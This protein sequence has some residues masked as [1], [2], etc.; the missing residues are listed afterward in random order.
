MPLLMSVERGG[1][2]AHL[3]VELIVPARNKERSAGVGQQ[4]AHE[5]DAGRTHPVRIAQ[6]LGKTRDLI[7]RDLDLLETEAYPAGA[8]PPR[9]LGLHEKPL[10]LGREAVAGAGARDQPCARSRLAVTGAI[11][12][13]HRP[14]IE[15]GASPVLRVR[16][17]ARLRRAALDRRPVARVDGTGHRESRAR[18][19]LITRPSARDRL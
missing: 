17:L 4:P 16:A 7:A 2:T 8:L 5:H 12:A 19:W 1:S 3:A 9:T 10:E 14:P 13:S 15:R 11:D 18:A 6:A